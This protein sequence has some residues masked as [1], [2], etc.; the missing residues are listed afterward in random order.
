M[1][2]VFGVG[3]KGKKQ[4]AVIPLDEV[5]PED[6]ELVREG[7]YFR[8]SIAYAI[9]RGGTGTSKRQSTIVFRRL[10]AYRAEELDNLREIAGQL[11]GGIRLE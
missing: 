4:D 7:A 6:L 1:D 11:V 3:I 10:P 9:T 2:G 5:S 8:L